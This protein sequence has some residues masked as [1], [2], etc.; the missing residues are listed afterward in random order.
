M[1]EKKK[2]KADFIPK[3]VCF[4]CNWSAN[5]VIKV[6]DEVEDKF[7]FPA[8]IR[9]IRVMCLG[10][11]NHSFILSAFESGADGVILLGCPP[12]DCHYYSGNDLV[13]GHFD[14]TV[15]LLH[16]LGIRKERLSLVQ[17]F[18]NEDLKLKKM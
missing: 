9:F 7:S 11:I 12:G 8:N 6:E 13:D 2:S 18:V 16:L 10:R 4:V 14:E 1:T 17:C 5:T 3:I 15:K